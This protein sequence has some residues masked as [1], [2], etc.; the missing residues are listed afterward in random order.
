[1]L[2]ALIPGN[3]AYIG[4][5]GP[6]QKLDRML[7]EIREDGITVTQHQLENIYGPSGLEI[8]AETPEEIGL[9]IL[10]EIKAVMAKKEGRSLRK[11]E[12][13]I[14]SRTETLIEKVRLVK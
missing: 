13:V 10:A 5:L 9:S 7:A 2:K 3:V 1:M 8:G 12:Q 11:S 4:S 6:R 14:H